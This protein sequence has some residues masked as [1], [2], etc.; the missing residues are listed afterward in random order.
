MANIF[1][2]NFNMSPFRNLALVSPLAV[3]VAAAPCQLRSQSLPTAYV[4]ALTQKTANLYV[5]ADV[6]FI[7]KK[8]NVKIPITINMDAEETGTPTLNGVNA[9]FYFT[10]QNDFI[11][12]INVLPRP[13][14]GPLTPY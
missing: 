10:R 8:T 11:S 2:E 9:E 13:I 3:I 4:D 6:N 1:L 14:F 12:Q 7:E 5:L